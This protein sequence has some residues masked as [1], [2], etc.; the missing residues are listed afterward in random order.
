MKNEN[1]VG[2][3]F[4]HPDDKDFYSEK[5]GTNIAL[6]RARLD[7]MYWLRAKIYNQI[8]EETIHCYR[9][10]GNPSRRIM[11]LAKQAEYVTSCINDEKRVLSD[12]LKGQS[13]AVE[14]VKRVRAKESSL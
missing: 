5:V 12:Y 7:A 13:R 3:A 2:E 1:Y 14:S 11:S 8:V 9:S 4:L 10:N 6:S